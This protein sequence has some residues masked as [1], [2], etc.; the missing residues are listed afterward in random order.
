M[1]RN[2]TLIF[3]ILLLFE[4]AQGQVIRYRG[5]LNSGIVLGEPGRKEISYPMKDELSHPGSQSFS[6]VLK[7]GV[8]LELITPFTRE[9]EVGLQLGYS[10]FAGHTPTAPL[11]NFFLSRYNPLRKEGVNLENFYPDDALIYDTKIFNVLGTA[12]W[13]FL[14]Y[15]KEL[16]F[17]M[18]FFGGVSFT[19]TDFTFE[20]PRERVSRK[21]GVLFA[22]GTQNSDYPK[23]AGV[24]GGAG[25]GAT[26]RLSDKLDI[27]FDF[28]SSL[29]HS[30][31]VNGVPNFNYV[32]K[33]GRASMERINAIS[34]V[35]HAGVGIIYSS[36]PDRRISK[37]NITRSTNMNRNMFW[38]KNRSR[39]YN[40]SKRR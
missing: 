31:I 4:N 3:L 25:L 10:N 40:K 13:Y 36:I 17:F 35:G 39:P 24:T 23:R 6:S 7:P 18:K 2:L 12:R 16:S 32:S 30:D 19:G 38:K 29:I 20:D 22:R 14:Q 8:E 33:D 9:F 37:N 27:Y 15:S 34:A 26:Y 28:N 21:V 5:S 1:I 11:Y